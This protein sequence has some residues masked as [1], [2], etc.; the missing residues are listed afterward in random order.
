MKQIGKITLAKAYDVLSESEMKLVFGGSG[1]GSGS[2]TSDVDLDKCIGKIYYT[3]YEG[4]GNEMFS[5]KLCASNE[6]VA[7]SGYCEGRSASCKDKVVCT[8][9]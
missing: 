1:S 7:K 5:A 2:E 6:T 4:P 3:C 8:A 9:G